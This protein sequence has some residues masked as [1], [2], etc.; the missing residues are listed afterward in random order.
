MELMVWMVGHHKVSG[1]VSIINVA[2]K[3]K[4]MDGDQS[5]H[6][7]VVVAIQDTCASFVEKKTTGHLSVEL[8]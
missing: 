7:I 2:S 3:A 6:Q 1:L 8:C 5:N 4:E